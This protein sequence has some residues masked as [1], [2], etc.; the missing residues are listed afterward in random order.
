MKRMTENKGF[1][2][3]L[4]KKAGVA[5]SLAMLAF[6]GAFAAPDAPAGR[7]NI[8]H[9][10]ADDHAFQ[11]ISAYGHPV[12]RLAPTPNIDRLARGGML[13]RRAYVENSLCAPSRACLL[14]G[15][16]SHQNGQ[17]GL[18][19]GIDAAKPFFT[20]ALQQQGYQTGI[21]G[22][23]HLPC[24]PRGFDHYRLLDDQGEYY[25]PVFKTR[26]GNGAHAKE[27]GYATTLIGDH[28]IGFLEKRDKTRPFC[29]LIHHKA[30]HRNW[31][32]EEKYLSL[33]ENTE[34]PLPA[35]FFDSYEGRCEAA[36][37][38]KMSIARDMTMVYDL[39]LDELK[40]IQPFNKEGHVKWWS[41]DMARLTA[42]QRAS[43][44]A[45]YAPRNAKFLAEKPDGRKLAEWKYQRYVK[46]YLRCVKS[47]DDEVGRLLDYLDKA[48]LREN[49]IIVYTSDQGFYLGEHGWF[50]KRFMYEESFRT[51]LIISWPGRIAPGGVCDALV[52]N[53]DF[54]PTY[55]AVSGA[56]VPASLPGRSLTPLFEGGETPDWR[57]YLYYHYYDYPGG[58]Q[59]RRHD[60][61][62][63]GRYKYIHFYGGDGHGGGNL[64]C[65]ELYDLASD[66][67]ETV[68]LAG[69][70]ECAEVE[71]RMQRAL[72]DFRQNLNVDEY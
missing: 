35:S 51:P 69:R 68:N 10:M 3:G 66:P 2:T 18:G 30:P 19:R 7:P 12:S 65:G 52:Q 67:D 5:V 23:W 32:P 9:I 59:V 55:L 43:W 24:D 15:L 41:R 61:V 28:A 34:F 38:Q 14:T 20:E 70:P 64:N 45:A 37:T 53:I 6:G 1:V 72:A 21:V 36:S 13:F 49:T 27:E 58:H 63:D 8:I 44:R 47:V 22:K 48:G 56:A 39:K 33:Y 54:A 26:E 40:D 50:D 62:R 31:L 16:Y 71:K 25:N 17:R 60:G 42:E 57:E 46:D 29:L 11:A 4:R